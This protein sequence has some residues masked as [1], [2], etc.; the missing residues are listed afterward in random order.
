[1]RSLPFWGA[2]TQSHL[3]VNEIHEDSFNVVSE[4]LQTGPATL[5]DSVKLV[6][7]DTLKFLS[8]HEGILFDVVFEDAFTEK[9]KPSARASLPHM[10]KRS[11]TLGCTPLNFCGACTNVSH[12]GDCTVPIAIQLCMNGK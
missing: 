6:N 5:R 9:G 4:L 10:G 8:D 12:P 3:T 1:M 7:C 11:V 2:V